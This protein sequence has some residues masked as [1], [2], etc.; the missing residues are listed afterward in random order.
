MVDA[1]GLVVD[2][3]LP[4]LGRAA[5]KP[6]NKSA[7]QALTDQDLSQ[8]VAI[9]RPGHPKTMMHL[10]GDLAANG[11]VRQTSREA[12]IVRIERQGK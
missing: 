2:G 1:Q 10:M 3:A 5:E 9:T 7:G 12:L 11:A 4:R 8:C 6:A